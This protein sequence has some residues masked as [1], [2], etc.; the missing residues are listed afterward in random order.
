MIAELF[1]AVAHQ[2]A[3]AGLLAVRQRLGGPACGEEEF[4]GPLVEV[5]GPLGPAFVPGQFQC[6]Q[7]VVEALRGRAA[8]QRLALAYEVV[9]EPHGIATAAEEELHRVQVRHEGV[10]EVVEEG[11]PQCGVMG[12]RGPRGVRP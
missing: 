7:D 8:V 10:G 3:P 1:V 12:Q 9:R 6:G 11:T 2:I 4:T 5:P